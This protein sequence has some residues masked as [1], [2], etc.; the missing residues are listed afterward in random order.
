MLRPTWRT[1]IACGP[2]A[3]NRPAPRHVGDGTLL[4]CAMQPPLITIDQSD[5]LV[6]LPTC[7][8]GPVQISTVPTVPIAVAPV[9]TS[10][11]VS[12]MPFGSSTSRSKKICQPGLPP[13]L[14][15]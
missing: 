6:S 2:G 11:A 12:V 8:V 1:L 15:V 7:V 14:A 5:E 10:S 9:L 4:P 3:R 13:L